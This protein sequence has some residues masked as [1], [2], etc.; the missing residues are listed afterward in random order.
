VPVEI[1]FGSNLVC[2]MAALWLGTGNLSEGSR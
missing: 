2:I 1:A